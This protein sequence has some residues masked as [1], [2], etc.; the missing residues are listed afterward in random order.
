MKIL[1]ID[2]GTTKSAWLLLDKDNP[3]SIIS[4]GYIDSN[5]SAF[6]TLIRDWRNW[7]DF[8]VGIEGI[9]SYGMPVGVE[10]FFTCYFIGKMMGECESQKISNVEVVRKDVKIYL[11]GQTKAT[12]ANIRQALV[13]KYGE[14]GVKKN[15]GI[16]Y[17]ISKDMWSALAIAD[18]VDHNVRNNIYF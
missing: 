2:P 12:D 4:F 7:E 17:G 11:C 10:V 5:L 6:K 16:T 3:K 1:A 8:M 14:C 15:P 13:D 18:Y 9:R